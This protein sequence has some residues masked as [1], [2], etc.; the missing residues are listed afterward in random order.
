MKVNEVLTEASVAD[1]VKAI[2]SKPGLIANPGNIRQTANKLR[3]DRDVGQLTLA[4]IKVWNNLISAERDKRQGLGADGTIDDQT[5][6][7][8]L[9]AFIQKNLVGGS[10]TNLDANVRSELADIIN[11]VTDA[12]DRA[13]AARVF[14][15]LFGQLIG[16]S[17]VARSQVSTQTDTSTTT[18]TPPPRTVNA[19]KDALKNARLNDTDIAKVREAISSLNINPV[20][21]NDPSVIALLKTL[22]IPVA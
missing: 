3:T 16:T 8:L 6:K 7:T 12:R 14:P 18:T 1:T 10:L 17:L 21:T 22:G 13:D 9:T 11:Q 5:Y 2:A 19:V 4:M 20:R 15:N